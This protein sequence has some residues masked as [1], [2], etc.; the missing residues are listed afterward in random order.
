MFPTKDQRRSPYVP[1]EPLERRELLS[2]QPWGGQAQMIGQ[3]L[4]VA[5][6]PTITGAG[7]TIAIIDSGV[8]YNHPSLGGGLGSS[9]KVVGG[10]DFVSNDADPMS[11]TNAHGT[12]AAGIAAADGFVYKGLRYQG[13]APD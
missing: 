9:Y 4:G 6:F 13:I 12:G 8:D 3:N 1:I 5:N 11:D 10:Y 7:Q 2:G